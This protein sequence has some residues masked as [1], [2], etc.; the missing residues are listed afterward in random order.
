[1]SCIFYFDRTHQ[2]LISHFH[3]SLDPGD[4]THPRL[5]FAT[6][7]GSKGLSFQNVLLLDDFLHPKLMSQVVAAAT[8]KRD[9]AASVL[10][11][12]PDLLFADATVINVAYV[13]MTRAEQNLVVSPKFMEWIG[14]FSNAIA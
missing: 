11:G 10:L 5:T 6:S 14:T 9:R 8:R 3:Y 13:A 4:H 12:R 7:H 1:M 2:S